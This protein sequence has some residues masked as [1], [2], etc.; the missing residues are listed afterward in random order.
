M[1]EFD[2]EGKNVKGGEFSKP[3]TT[4]DEAFTHFVMRDYDK[5]RRTNWWELYWMMPW[6]F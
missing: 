5:I 4:C 1:C 2:M 6:S 3:A